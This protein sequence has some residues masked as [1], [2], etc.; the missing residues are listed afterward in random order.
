TRSTRD[1]S[2]DVCSSD[3]YDRTPP[4]IQSVRAVTS[5]DGDPGVEWELSDDYLNPKGVKLEFRWD[6]QGRFESIDRNAPL[7]PRGARYW[8]QIGRA[9]CRAAGQRAEG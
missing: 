2:S 7:G 1:W 6:G 5:A 3:L 9:S 4:R 8:K